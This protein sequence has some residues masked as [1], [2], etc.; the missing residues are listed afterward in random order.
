MSCPETKEDRRLF[1]E[2]ELAVASLGG[3]K[4]SEKELKMAEDYIEGRISCDEFMHRADDLEA[5]D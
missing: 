4:A 2:Q 3:K 5:D 1:V